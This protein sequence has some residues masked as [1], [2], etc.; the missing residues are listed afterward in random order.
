MS[1]VNRARQEAR[2]YTSNSADF[3]VPVKFT[4][5]EGWSIVVNARATKHSFN[6]DN[7][8]IPHNSRN[9]SVTVHES[10]L[11]SQ[12]YPVRNER[13]DVKMINHLVTWADATGRESTYI[14]NEQMPDEALGLIIFILGDYAA[15]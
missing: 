6:Y 1:L 4:H 8:G 3:A 10:L 5:P 11:I 9:A 14:I 7:N 2:R 12:G 13:G 15:Y